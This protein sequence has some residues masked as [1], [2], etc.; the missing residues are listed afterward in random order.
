MLNNKYIKSIVF[1]G[2]A[3]SSINA[4][5]GQA[6]GYWAVVCQNEYEQ[7][8]EYRNKCDYEA[9]KEYVYFNGVT[10]VIANKKLTGTN[11]TNWSQGSAN[12]SQGSASCLSSVITTFQYESKMDPF[13][14]YYLVTESVYLPLVNSTEQSRNVSVNIGV[15]CHREWREGEIE[16]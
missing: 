4:V 8:T 1:L 3:T 12:W 10:Y 11:Y 9:N 6:N 2:M 14:P 7:Q 13:S 5:A 15:K 16:P